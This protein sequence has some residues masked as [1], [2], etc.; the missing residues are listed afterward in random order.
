MLT[1]PCKFSYSF[2]EFQI[3]ILL[4]FFVVACQPA[5]LTEKE[6]TTFVN[7]ESNGL[8]KKNNIGEMEVKVTYRPTDLLVARE[9]T[10]EQ[11]AD[12]A[13]IRVLK[14]KY[15]KYLYFILSLSK[16]NKEALHQADG[17]SQYSELVQTLS[18]R[19]GEYVNLTTAAS[20]T[21]PVGDF[22]LD[23][24]YGLS[25]ATNML[26]AFNKEKSSGK[27]WV[28][29]NLNELGLGTGNVR[30]RFLMKNVTNAPHVIFSTK[31][32]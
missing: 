30:F 27:E 29:F 28:Q 18:F 19:M 2:K 23:R 25:S 1:T 20:D 16:N 10:T 7:D 32:K 5:S 13:K 15:G 3:L 11:A 17:F 12:T 22:I 21:I 31:E 14:K 6:L 4:L 24:T 26:F 8:C 9:L